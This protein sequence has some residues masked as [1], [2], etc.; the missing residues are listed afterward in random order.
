MRLNSIPSWPLGRQHIG[1]RTSMFGEVTVTES[2]NTS[3]MSR[4]REGMA[5]IVRRGTPVTRQ[6]LPSDERSA[7]TAALSSSP[8]FALSRMSALM[9]SWLSALADKSQSSGEMYT[10]KEL[11]RREAFVG[12]TRN[13]PGSMA[14]GVLVAEAVA[15]LPIPK[16]LKPEW[17][18]SAQAQF[19]SR[20]GRSRVWI[21]PRDPNITSCRWCLRGNSD[22]RH[23]IG[24]IPSWRR[25]PFY[26]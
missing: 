3:Q 6:T 20:S 23:R 13:D 19:S 25:P 5:T 17:S 14:K 26:A 10:G 21:A 16:Y 11:P 8:Q 1:W 9:A 2:G 18:S 7:N 22:R 12:Q 4:H 15:R 24:G